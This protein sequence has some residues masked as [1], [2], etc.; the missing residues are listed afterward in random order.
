MREYAKQAGFQS[1][2]I[3]PIQNDLWR[4]YRLTA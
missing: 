4:F 1:V 2:E 3:L